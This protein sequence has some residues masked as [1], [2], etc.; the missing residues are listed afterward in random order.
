MNLSASPPPLTRTAMLVAS[1]A[2]SGCSTILEGGGGLAPEATYA[3]SP[4]N[5]ASLTAVIRDCTE[6]SVAR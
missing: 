3:A 1:L 4:A 6:P 5:I 2:L